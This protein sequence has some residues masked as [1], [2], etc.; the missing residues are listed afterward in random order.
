MSWT[1]KFEVNEI[2]NNHCGYCSDSYDKTTTETTRFENHQFEDMDMFVHR[3]VRDDGSVKNKGLTKYNDIKYGHNF[4]GCSDC[5]TTV[6]IISGTLEKI[7]D[8]KKK[9]QNS[10]LIEINK[11]RES[12]GLPCVNSYEVMINLKLQKNEN[13]EKMKIY[14]LKKRLDEENKK[15][16]EKRKLKEEENIE[17]RKLKE[18]EN[19][20]K[21]KKHFNKKCRWGDKCYRKNDGCRFK[22]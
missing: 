7:K 1:I 13:E 9:F 3:Y 4:G 17:K 5:D 14:E 20:E 10:R 12:K 22:H 2:E 8:I 21:R 19:I 11:D 6:Y 18:E 16:M 15:Y